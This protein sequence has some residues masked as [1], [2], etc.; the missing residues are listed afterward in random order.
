MISC[1]IWEIFKNIVFYGTFPVSA[2]DPLKI[3]VLNCFMKRTKINY[4]RR[5]PFQSFQQATEP[6][7]LKEYSIELVKSLSKTLSK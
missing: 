6:K 4:F 7:F 3:T 1:G 5:V 2:S